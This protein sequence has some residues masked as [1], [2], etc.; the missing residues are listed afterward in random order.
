MVVALYKNQISNVCM[1]INII[2]FFVMHEIFVRT[3]FEPLAKKNTFPSFNA[4]QRRE[5]FYPLLVKVSFV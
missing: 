2:Y 1:Y 4:S 3:V 5:Y